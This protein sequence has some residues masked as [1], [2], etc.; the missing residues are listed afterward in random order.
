MFFK[1]TEMGFIKVFVN[2][3]DTITGYMY[4][5]DYKYGDKAIELEKVENWMGEI[6]YILQL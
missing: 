4:K 5:D 1:S 6:H 2:N 3:D